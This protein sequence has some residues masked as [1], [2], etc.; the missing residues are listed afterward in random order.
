V[1]EL[2]RPACGQQN[3]FLRDTCPGSNHCP[4]CAILLFEH[5]RSNRVTNP[6]APKKQV[7]LN[8]ERTSKSDKWHA[9]HIYS[10]KPSRGIVR[11]MA[12]GHS[13]RAWFRTGS[14]RQQR[15]C[16]TFA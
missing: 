8:L 5:V 3:P 1:S 6:L 12:L 16:R 11:V 13:P 14:V 2:S 10:T 9:G 15:Q 7:S 4:S